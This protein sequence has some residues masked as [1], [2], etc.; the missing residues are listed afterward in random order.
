MRRQRPPRS[1]L[2]PRYAAG[3][4][5]PFT[6]PRRKQYR[7]AA[8]LTAA[9]GLALVGGTLWILR[10]RDAAS[11]LARAQTRNDPAI[12]RLHATPAA[13]P[14]LE[15]WPSTDT[16][17]TRFATA[18]E[19]IAFL[20]KYVTLHSPVEDTAFRIVYHDNG[21]APSDWDMRVA[22]RVPPGGVAAWLVGAQRDDGAAELAPA[23][24]VPPSWALHGPGVAYRRPG[25]A[26]LVFEQD[27]VVLMRMA[28][29]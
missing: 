8:A 20:G 13:A 27:R 16:A 5:N 11:A 25:T 3:V 4:G 17:S 21:F 9:S 23:E 7:I 28:T 10:V 22:V 19:R 1:G 29:M 18:S 14:R 12:A 24:I 6:G 2:A 26:L 15:R